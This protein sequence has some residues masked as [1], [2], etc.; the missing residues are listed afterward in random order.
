MH[1]MYLRTLML[2]HS[3]T[4]LTD[5]FAASIQIVTNNLFLTIDLFSG[6]FYCDITDHIPFYVYERNTHRNIDNRPKIMPFGEK[7]QQIY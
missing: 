2:Y 6:M 5:S 7:M 4:P 1:L 3:L